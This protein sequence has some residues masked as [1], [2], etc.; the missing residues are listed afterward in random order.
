MVSMIY[1]SLAWIPVVPAVR[2]VP[3]VSSVSEQ[4][5]ACLVTHV[6]NDQGARASDK[7]KSVLAHS[8]RLFFLSAKSEKPWDAMDKPLSSWVETWSP[9]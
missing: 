9:A 2:W 1:T 3:L 4:A 8:L 5:S 7:C 6:M